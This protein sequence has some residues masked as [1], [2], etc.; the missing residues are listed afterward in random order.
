MLFNEIIPT[1]RVNKFQSLLEIRKE[2]S[3]NNSYITVRGAVG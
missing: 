2:K 3:Y 1:K